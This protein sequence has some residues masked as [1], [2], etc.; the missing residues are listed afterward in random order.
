[1]WTPNGVPSDLDD[2]VIPVAGGHFDPT[3][4]IEASVGR[5]TIQSGGI[6]NTTLNATLT[7]SGANG[8][9]L[10]NGG[11]FN[12]NSDTVV[13]TNPDATM[14]GI[15]DFY[16]VTIDTG[17]SL[18]MTGGSIMRI[19]GTMSNSG[20]AGIW[21][22]AQL[23]NATVEYN[24]AA[25]TVLNP[26]GATPGY[27]NLILSGSG[28]KTMPGT[29][30]NIAEDFTMSGTATVIALAAIN[31]AGDFTIGASN[32]IDA[33][34]FTHTIGGNL[35]NHGI[36]TGTG[37]TFDIGGDFTS[38]NTFTATNST[39]TIG[40]NFTNDSTFTATGSNITFDGV[41]AQA[42]GGTT[43]VAFN[44]LTIS[45]TSAAVS[46][47]TN[48]SVG[49][50]L[51]VDS[52]AVLNPAAGVIVSGTGTLTGNGTVNVTR[53]AATADF[54]S[55]YTI[56]NTTLTNLTVAYIG[57]AAQTVSALT[58]GG[59]KINNASGATLAGNAT[60]NGLLTLTNGNITTGANNIYVSSTGSVSGGST[61]SHIVGNLRK[62]IVT[63]ATNKTFEIGDGSVYAPVDISFGSVSVVGDLTFSTASGDCSNIA[64]SDIDPAKSVNRCWSATN[65]GVAF[66]DYNAVFT[67]VPGDLDGPA[68]YTIFQA[69]KYSG[70]WTNLTVG[71]KNA[72]NTQILGA[73]SFGDFQIGNENNSAPTGT[74]NSA[75][76]QTDGS[77][78]V[79]ISIE[80][81]DTENNNTKAKIEYETDSDGLCNGPWAAATLLGP[82]AADFNDSGGAPDIN[83]ANPYQ[84]G[85]TT[86]TRIITSS[87]SNTI[88]FEWDSNTDLPSANGAQCLRLTVNDDALD[89]VTPA[90]QT[91]AVDNVSS[92]VAITAPDISATVRGVTIFTFT[93]SEPGTQ[94][95]N[96]N[97]GTWYACAS[98]NTFSSLADFV[99]L[100][101][102]LFTLNIRDT[103]AIGNIGTASRSFTKDTIA[104]DVT[105]NKKVGQSDPTNTSPVEFTAVFDEPI[106]TGTFTN[107]DIDLSTSTATTGAV[108]VTEVA[109][110][111]GTTFNISVVVTADGD[112]T[113]TIPAGGI[114]DPAGNTSIVSI[115]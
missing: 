68:D 86:T 47:N 15:T 29:S 34:G 28:A 26:N 27:D 41:V 11:I 100:G 60:V 70:S 59:L 79:D 72:T 45:N 32:T 10:D 63:G 77:G 43:A 111:N 83:N 36:F 94:E 82:A 69:A 110:N 51:T 105:I 17:A 48:F 93:S 104:P 101:D 30:L 78:D 74:F 92:I 52:S 22:A 40:G 54:S 57:S 25:Q 114:S 71:T 98:T 64:T 80:V 67:F 108:T 75:T 46:A 97:G 44:N 16:N 99:S 112:V 107:A 38:D 84:V 76:Q 66:T 31:T 6:L 89:Q 65:T 81:D 109:P 61:G 18:L 7:I 103:D 90:T 24:G 106:N 5:M 39:M 20:G 85:S 23:T 8:A 58:Y 113:A 12:H 49:G 21:K 73:T 42:I 88:T 9:W 56:S 102:V 2:V 96:I 14:A 95:C 62:Y 115:S 4:P 19:A 87:G 55:Q 53:T 33:G 37:S 3:L 1:N 91:V 50:N 13:F 35:V